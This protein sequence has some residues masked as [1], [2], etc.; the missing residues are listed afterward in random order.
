MRQKL[1]V[2][3]MVRVQLLSVE[4]AVMAADQQ[5]IL[6]SMKMQ[7]LYRQ[8]EQGILV[9]RYTLRNHVPVHRLLLLR[10]PHLQRMIQSVQVVHLVLAR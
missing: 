2:Y 4:K 10:L 7:Q 3:L 1:H 8:E 6:N 5:Y 9:R